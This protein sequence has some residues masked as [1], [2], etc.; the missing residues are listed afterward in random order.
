MTQRDPATTYIRI[1]EDLQR[2][3]AT[4]TESQPFDPDMVYEIVELKQELERKHG[5]VYFDVDDEH[6]FMHER[7]FS[8]QPAIRKCS[9]CGFRINAKS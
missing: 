7:P 5:I 1:I 8:L 9:R 3:A 2:L 6:G 4:S